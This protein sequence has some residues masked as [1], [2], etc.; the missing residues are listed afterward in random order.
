ML[1]N[2]HVDGGRVGTI[3]RAMCAPLSALST[4]VQ[5][6]GCWLLHRGHGQGRIVVVAVDAGHDF[7]AE[8]PD[9]F[10]VGECISCTRPLP[11]HLPRRISRFGMV[12]RDR[13][14]CVEFEEALLVP[15]ET[16]GGQA[17]LA[18]VRNEPTPDPFAVPDVAMLDQIA[19]ARRIYDGALRRSLRQLKNHLSQAA[20]R[21][22]EAEVEHGGARLLDSVAGTARWLFGSSA[23]YVAQPG[24]SDDKF[25]FVATDRVQTSAF[26]RLRLGPDEGMGG[27][28]RRNRQTVRTT[29]YAVDPRLRFAPHRETRAEGFT[30]AACTPIMV[31]NGVCG[32]VY[33]AERSMRTFSDTDLALLEHFTGEVAMALKRDSLRRIHL[34]S[35][36][37]EER[38]ALAEQLHDRVIAH[39][40]EIGFAARYPAG[41]AAA[42]ELTEALTRIGASAEQCLAELRGCIAE[43]SGHSGGRG[44]PV[45]TLLAMCEA[46]PCRPLLTPRYEL[47][48]DCPPETL[49]SAPLFDALA[50]I[51]CEG[52]RNADRHSGAMTVRLRLDR[53]SS[54][55]ELAVD[56]DGCGIPPAQLCDL[57]DR[58][59]HLGL[60]RMR[61]CA[62]KLGGR[63]T[64]GRSQLGGL[65]IT[66]SL[67]SGG[68]VQ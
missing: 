22:V 44:A 34:D 18:I 32:L 25:L 68:L 59:G 49:L 4:L 5:G 46:V 61:R 13:E 29:D 63:L 52:I 56:D 16:P 60:A 28:A 47:G 2:V 45:A 64:F 37:R 1:H 7:G 10:L 3:A 41:V 51:M 35:V 33:I 65:C 26:R 48:V 11:R 24:L 57:L 54:A 38:R 6:A 21:L 30:S 23:A 12:S 66:A 42:D 53:S 67:P 36:R 43:R 50:V 31:D 8:V 55:I 17:W 27:L 15:W 62:H 19:A 39:L 40:L 14:L 58:P 9:D 20:Q